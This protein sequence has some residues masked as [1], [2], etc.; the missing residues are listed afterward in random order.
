MSV[1][2]VRLVANNGE[3]FPLK[4]NDG[5]PTATVKTECPSCATSPLEV[6][7]RGMHIGA[8]D[9]YHADAV[10]KCCGADVGRIVVRV[11]TMFG[12]EEDH[13]VLVHGRPR[14]YGGDA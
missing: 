11:S 8:R 6:S 1:R 4:T 14:V 10:A 3:S 2:S 13:A 5:A 9:E 12:L 7:G